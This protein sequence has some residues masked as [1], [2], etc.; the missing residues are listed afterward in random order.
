MRYRL[1]PLNVESIFPARAAECESRD[2]DVAR[3]EYL[4]VWQRFVEGLG[5]IPAGHRSDLPLWLDHFDSLWLACTHAIPAATAFGVKPEVSL[6]DHSRTTAALAVALWRWHVAHDA[7]GPQAAAAMRERADYGEAKLL[8]IQGD[9]FGIQAFVFADGGQTRKHAAKLLRGRSFQ[10]SL[11]TEIA[12]VAVLDALSL[13]PT[14]QV[15]N[16]AGKFLI[17]A[18]N[19]PDTVERLQR[20]RESFERWFL[21][22]TFGQAGVGLAWSPATC[23]DLVRDRRTGGNAFRTLLDRLHRTLEVA[24]HRRFDLASTGARIFDQDYPHGPCDYNGRLPAD[25]P[26]SADHPAS[27]ALSRDQLAIGNALLRTDRLSIWREDARVA[28]GVR[29]ELPLFGYR[30]TFDEVGDDPRRFDRAAGAGELRRCWDFSLPRHG[31]PML[32]DGLA[33]RFIGGHV[34][35]ASADDFRSPRYADLPDDERARPGE[36][37]TLDMIA[38]ADRE[39]AQDGTAGRGIAALGV[40]K[41]DVDD[42]GELFRVG[43]EQPS[44]AKWAALSRQVHAFFAVHVPAMLAH[45]FPSMYTVFAGGDDF[46][47]IGPWHTTQR[48]AARMRTDFARY[49]AGNAGVRFSAGIAT[50]KPGAPL[51]AMVALAEN[52]LEQSKA[53]EGKD[54]VTCFGQT[55]PWRDWPSLEAA[56]SRLSALGA[57]DV[58]SRGYLY[59]LL[60]FVDAAERERRGD[61]RAA[62]AS[63]WRAHFRYRTARHAADRRHGLDADGRRRLAERLTLDLGVNGIDALGAAF[64]VPLFNHLYLTRNR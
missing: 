62:E 20:L 48:A 8:L 47:L 52:A 60:H 17:V 14:S 45:D 57:D 3:A 21:D 16:A 1:A 23:N 35:R 5:Q 54:A 59:A 31:Q 26:A 19:T 22:A 58:V 44:F 37:A 42:L 11:F 4:A 39:V 12:A 28:S 49:A 43:L 61:A 33:R 51:Q 50:Q 30:I 64:R 46:L 25:R 63:L 32:F 6:Y 9:F 24:K 13:P 2:R 55:V 29:L 10:V 41:G 18:P 56:A 38:R 27:C 36:L 40:L 7:C 34:P 15:V 53:R